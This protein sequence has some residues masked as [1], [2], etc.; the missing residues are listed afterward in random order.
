MKKSKKVSAIETQTDANLDMQLAEPGV[1]GELT[2]LH[3]VLIPRHPRFDYLEAYRRFKG[4]KL[5]LP[6]LSAGAR[7]TQSVLT[8]GI[9]KDEPEEHFRQKGMLVV[10]TGGG[11]FG[12]PKEKKDETTL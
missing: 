3:T 12:N 1:P 11:E 9:S 7:N 2:K 5:G 10:G 6:M 4:Y 8:E